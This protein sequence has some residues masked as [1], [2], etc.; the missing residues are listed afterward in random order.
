MSAPEDS[1]PNLGDGN[2]EAVNEDGNTALHRAADQGLDAVVREPPGPG[3]R[4]ATGIQLRI[5]AL[6]VLEVLCRM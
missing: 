6:K 2:I 1:P 5:R 3:A 4:R